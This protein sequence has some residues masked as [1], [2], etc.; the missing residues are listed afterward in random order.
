[1]LGEMYNDGLGVSQDYQQAKKWYEKAAS[2][3][4]AQAQFDLGVMNE[5]GQGGSI[6]LKQARHYYERSC[7]NGL[8]KGCERLKALSDK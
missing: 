5:L 6:D 4:D 1:M 2:Q 7:N 8:K 3:N